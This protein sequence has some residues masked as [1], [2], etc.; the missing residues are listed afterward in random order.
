MATNLAF[1]AHDAVKMTYTIQPGASTADIQGLL[2]SA[3]KGT[4]FLFAAGTHRITDTLEVDT[5][6]ITIKGAGED[7]TT[8]LF[9]MAPGYGI[10]V[11]GSDGSYNGKL[12][13]DISKGD[14]TI[15]L[16]N[17]SGLKA[18]DFLKI[19]QGNTD[20]W[21]KA[22]GYE[23]VVGTDYQ[24]KLAI[25]ETLVEIKSVSGNTVSLK[26][27]ITHDMDSAVTTVKT[28]N[29]L[30]DVHLSDFKVTYN[31][32]TPDPDNFASE[33]PQW[34]G[35]IAVYIEKTVDADVQNVSIINAPGHSM[36]FRT[37]LSPNVNNYH[38][39]GSHNKGPTGD[40]YGIQ[41]TETY[42]GTFTNLDI[43]NTRHAFVF[44]AWHTEVGN[45]VHILSTNRDINF[46][47]G[48]DYDNNVVV[49]SDIYRSGDTIWRLVSPGGSQHPFTDIY[50]DNTIV[51]GVASGG[52][53][54]DEIYGWDLGA[55]LDGGAGNDIIHG[56]T[57]NDVILSG[58][59]FDLITLGGGKDIIAFRPGDGRDDISGF[60]TDDKIVLDNFLDVSS[61]S[62]V[63]ISGATDTTITVNGERIAILKGIAASQ[64]TAGNF[65]FNDDD[66]FTPPQPADYDPGVDPGPG[67]EPEPEPEPQ[68]QPEPEPEP[69]PGTGITANASSKIE[70]IAGTTGGDTVSGYA[71]QINTGDAINLGAGFDTL[72]ILSGSWTFDSKLYQKLSGIDHLDLTAPNDRAKVILDKSFLQR[73]D[74]SELTISFGS[75]KGVVDA[76]A[77]GGEYSLTWQGNTAKVTLKSLPP[78]EPP[79][80]EGKIYSAGSKTD[81]ITGTSGNDTVQAYNSQLNTADKYDMKG[82]HDILL[83]R[84][85]SVDF[86]TANFKGLKGI[87]QFSFSGSVKKLVIGESFMASTDKG[88]LTLLYGDGIDLLDASG[89]TKSKYDVVLK[90]KGDVMLSANN[91]EVM[92]ANGTTGKI[93]GGGGND[94]LYGSDGIDVLRG[95]AGNDVLKGGKGADQFSGGS[96]SDTFQYESI[97]DGGDIIADFQAGDKLDLTALFDA[98]GLGAATVQSA[99]AG[100]YLKIAKQGAD[101]LVSFDADGAVGTAHAATDLALLKGAALPDPS[102]LLV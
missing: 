96:G 81:S 4:T 75:D 25:N 37:A 90:G 48:P 20:E 72:K 67:P 53:K 66:Y 42:Y 60:G 18:G 98:N 88:V 2:N 86:N 58:K 92:I 43:Q 46:H 77:L 47:G 82:G 9:D 69:Q 22:N 62:N 51:F 1:I 24:D 101:V 87:D 83:F 19:E 95:G 84:S 78:P 89:F 76:S 31:L 41:A 6:N 100:G 49:E 30:R 13:G 11:Q 21:L 54:Q 5:G 99:I 102:A 27:P 8:L 28:M 35:K 44:S 40:G 34:E 71:G 70:T 94:L 52:E 33:E 97:L 63:G 93:D 80:V 91:D 17:A 64:L 73:T 32:G 55:W 12:S 29:L 79:P 38:A 61:F 56:G 3:E 10:H 50:G 7:K 36:E 45:E 26:T 57:G 74:K 59:G 39:D 65:I 23:N 14:T 68:P 15:T 16:Q 85:G